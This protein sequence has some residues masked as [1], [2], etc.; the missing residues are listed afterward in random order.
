MLS[1]Y[2]C[3]GEQSFVRR[4]SVPTTIQNNNICPKFLELLRKPEEET[5]DQCRFNEDRNSC[6]SHDCV[7]SISVCEDRDCKNHLFYK[8]TKFHFKETFLS[9]MMRNCELGMILVPNDLV[10][11]DIAS[12]YGLSR[13]GVRV[14]ESR[15]LLK[16]SKMILKNRSDFSDIISTYGLKNIKNRMNYHFKVAK[17]KGLNH[18]HNYR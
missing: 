17:G 12:M 11:E 15:G 8:E 2:G 9:R 4:K 6:L 3:D 10:L 14:I 13:E 5:C 1:I 16:I 18:V 7:S